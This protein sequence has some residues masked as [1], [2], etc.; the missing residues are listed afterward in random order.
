MRLTHRCTR[1]IVSVTDR[2]TFA[3]EWNP[4]KDEDEYDENKFSFSFPSELWEAGMQFTSSYNDVRYYLLSR[5]PKD[6]NYRDLLISF[7][8]NIRNLNPLAVDM[9]TLNSSKYYFLCQFC[10]EFCDR[11]IE[12]AMTRETIYNELLR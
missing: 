11:L 12:I 5:H 8:P 4:H 10:D 2:I 1:T 7:P 3:K 9:G 6:C